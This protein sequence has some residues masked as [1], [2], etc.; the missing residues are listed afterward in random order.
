[1]TK[2]LIKDRVSLNRNVSVLSIKTNH[3]INLPIPL[4]RPY[5]FN[6]IFLSL[7][8]YA[9][10]QILRLKIYSQ[11]Y[12]AVRLDRY[13]VQLFSFLKAYFLMVPKIDFL[14]IFVNHNKKASFALIVNVRPFSIFRKTWKSKSDPVAYVFYHF[15]DVKF[16]LTIVNVKVFFSQAKVMT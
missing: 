10:F 6:H 13:C 12:R 1:M 9:E 5:R 7:Q 11:T 4:L 2:N 14:T 8:F 15:A 3:W 16:V